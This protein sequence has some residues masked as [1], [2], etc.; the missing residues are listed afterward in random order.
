MVDE[1]EKRKFQRLEIP[2]EVTIEIVS[3]QGVPKGPPLLHVKSRNISMSG[4]SLET[5]SVEVHGI[6]LFSGLP[7]ARKNRLHLSIELIP[8]EPPLMATGEVQWYDTA[9]DIP[10]FIFRLGVVF[11][12]IKGGEKDQLEKYLKKH[13]SN[14][15]FFEKLLHKG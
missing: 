13:K 15:G 11:I 9:R 8:G 14:R 2:L 12:E 10:E 6:N 4:I 7:F 1:L 5:K 3:A